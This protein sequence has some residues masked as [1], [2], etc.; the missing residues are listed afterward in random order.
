MVKFKEMENLG[1]NYHNHFVLYERESYTLIQRLK[2][3]IRLYEQKK[4]PL[5][6]EISEL[7]SNTAPLYFFSF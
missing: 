6:Q 4:L 7:T 1:S 3:P 2:E 5:N